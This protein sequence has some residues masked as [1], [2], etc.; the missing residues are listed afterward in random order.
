M[1]V[2][3]VVDE[4]F[5]RISSGL[6]TVFYSVV[7]GRLQPEVDFGYVIRDETLRPCTHLNRQHSEFSNRQSDYAIYRDWYVRGVSL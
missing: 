6:F 3:L 4:A 7:T 2:V 1:M 5:K